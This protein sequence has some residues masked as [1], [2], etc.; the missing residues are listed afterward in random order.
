MGD[1]RSAVATAALCLFLSPHVAAGA[2]L[3][4]AR[5]EIAFTSARVCEVNAAFMVGAGEPVEVEH[6]LLLLEGAAVAL[7]AADADAGLRP[8]APPVAVGYSRSLLVKLPAAG[9]HT[10]SLHYQVSQPEAGA[11]RCPI[12]LPTTATDGRSHEIY[13]QVTLPAGAVPEGGGLPAFAWDDRQGV[14]RTGHVPSF[15]R[16]PFHLAGETAGAGG[17]NV[18]R[19]MDAIALTVVAIGSA[20]FVWRRRRR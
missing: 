10:Y 16:V 4:E 2:V 13:I 12:W 19:L 6:R 9:V 3:R 5:I 11:Y 17:V 14:A 20:L 18:A 8:S 7:S 1:W 15:V